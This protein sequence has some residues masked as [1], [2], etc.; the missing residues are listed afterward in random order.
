MHRHHEGRPPEQ[1]HER[2]RVAG[3]EQDVT[4]RVQ[5]Q[6]QLLPQMAPAATDAAHRDVLVARKIDDVAGHQEFERRLR[7]RG[8]V[9]VERID[10][11]ARVALHAR[12]GLAEKT[13]VD[14]DVHLHS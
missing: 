13:P 11:L 4:L 5:R 3:A 6:V 10:D 1:G 14:D 9:L 8:L 7:P 12:R 2:R